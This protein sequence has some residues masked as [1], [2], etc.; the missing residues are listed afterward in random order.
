MQ[1]FNAISILYEV[2]TVALGSIIVQYMVSISSLVYL[3]S[4]TIPADS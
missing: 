1:I 2:Q 3:K 4:D